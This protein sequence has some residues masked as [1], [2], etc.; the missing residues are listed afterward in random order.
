V[1]ERNGDLFLVSKGIT[2]ERLASMLPYFDRRDCSPALAGKMQTFIKPMLDEAN[3]SHELVE[4][5]WTL[6]GLFWNIALMRDDA[7]RK[8]GLDEA[9]RFFS[10]K[11]REQF[12]EV[13]AFMLRRHERMFPEMHERRAP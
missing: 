11:G 9:E 6:G 10:G 8:K 1:V 7:A 2:D 13:A 5:V 12:R 4:R 3:G